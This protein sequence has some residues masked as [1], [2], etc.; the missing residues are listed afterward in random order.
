M[1]T[2]IPLCAGEL[3]ALLVIA[4]FAGMGIGLCFASW[5]ASRDPSSSQSHDASPGSNPPPTFDKPERPA[6]PPRPTLDERHKYR[7]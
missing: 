2:V 7:S 1:T 6:N 3:L 5:I 4:A